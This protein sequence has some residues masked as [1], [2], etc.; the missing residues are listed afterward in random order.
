[1]PMEFSTLK[2]AKSL[3]AVLFFYIL[4]CLFVNWLLH[5][6]GASHKTISIMHFS[7]IVYAVIMASFFSIVF[8]CKIS[9]IIFK[10]LFCL[11]LIMLAVGII[12]LLIT[13]LNSNLQL[14]LSKWPCVIAGAYLAVISLLGHA[15]TS[16]DESLLSQADISSNEVLLSHAGISSNEA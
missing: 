12:S 11:G 4:V 6:F 5:Y 9:C 10:V 3:V 13:A 15:G 7:L 2:K 14:H 8:D 16:S 1:M